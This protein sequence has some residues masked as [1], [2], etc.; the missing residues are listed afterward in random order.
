MCGQAENKD[1]QDYSGRQY[2]SDYEFGGK[3]I[4][5]LEDGK[6]LIEIRNKLSVGDTLELLIPGKIDSL[7]FKIEELW[8]DETLESIPTVNPGKAEQKVILK[9]PAEVEEGWILRRKK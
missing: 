1:F 8:N 2:N 3:V 9:I 6:T 4:K 7:E 5:E